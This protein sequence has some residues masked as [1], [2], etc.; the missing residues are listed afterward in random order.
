[1]ILT[2]T[3]NQFQFLS[4]LSKMWIQLNWTGSHMLKLEKLFLSGCEEQYRCMYKHFSFNSQLTIKAYP[5][6]SLLDQAKH[7]T[8]AVL[9]ELTPLK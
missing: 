7:W 1:M 8:P 2:D 4:H 3:L 6:L 5:G 9:Q